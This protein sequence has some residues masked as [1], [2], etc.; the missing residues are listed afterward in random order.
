MKGR[1]IRIFRQSLKSELDQT[2][3]SIRNMYIGKAKLDD[4]L[5]MGKNSDDRS[6]LD[7]T[8][9]SSKS[10]TVFAKASQ[11]PVNKSSKYPGQGY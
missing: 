4:L 2:N 3:E 1:L 10:Q 9:T 6:G 5:G 11:S 8:G 7:Y